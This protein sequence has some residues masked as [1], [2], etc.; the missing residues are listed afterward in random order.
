MWLSHTH[1][2]MKIAKAGVQRAQPFVGGL[3]VT[4]NS[5]CLSRR[6]RCVRPIP[7]RSLGHPLSPV[8]ESICCSQALASLPA[9][10]DERDRL[11]AIRNLTRQITVIFMG[12]EG[13]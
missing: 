11:Q 7:K 12:G 13:L 9:S 6:S 8:A 10:L 2:H 3:G 1:E 4:P 5:L